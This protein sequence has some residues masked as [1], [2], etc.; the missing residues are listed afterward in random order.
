MQTPPSVYSALIVV[1]ATM[2]LF[3]FARILQVAFASLFSFLPVSLAG[4]YKARSW[5]TMLGGDIDLIR[6]P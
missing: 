6:S 2:L 3:T 4:F 5:E 1:T